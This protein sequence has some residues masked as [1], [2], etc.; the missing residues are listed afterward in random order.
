VQAVIDRIQ[1]AAARARHK[2]E[3]GTD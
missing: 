1:I 2:R 3:S